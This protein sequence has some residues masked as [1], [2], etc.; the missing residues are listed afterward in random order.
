MLWYPTERNKGKCR[1]VKFQHCNK[2]VPGVCIIL[3]A[4]VIGCGACKQAV[5][6]PSL[7]DAL[8]DTIVVSAEHARQFDDVEMMTFYGHFSLQAGDW[9]LRADSA[10]LYGALEDPDRVIINGTPAYIW[11]HDEQR[12]RDVEGSG[13]RIEYDRVRDIIRL[14]GGAF[15]DDG[16]RT[17]NSGFIEFDIPGNHVSAAGPEPGT[18]TGVHLR[19]QPQS[20]PTPVE[21]KKVPDRPADGVGKKR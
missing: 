7:Q 12:N 19:V 11:V 14:S 13:A 20:K 18:D 8:E 16:T 17:F 9:R 10:R 6:G 3:A 1:A 5:A 21:R 2:R 4:V 15:L